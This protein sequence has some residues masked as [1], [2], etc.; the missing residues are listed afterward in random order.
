MIP[1]NC[2]SGLRKPLNHQA[3]KGITA[4]A[5]LSG[6]PAKANLDRSMV[7]GGKR[8]SGTQEIPCGTS[9]CHHAR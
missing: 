5:G 8:T 7:E 6:P 2:H 9:Q 4:L 3:E 1:S